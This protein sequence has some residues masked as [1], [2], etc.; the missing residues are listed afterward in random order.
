MAA[1][2][3]LLL[4][5]G[6]E[7]VARHVTSLTN[8]LAEGA[9]RLDVAV[10]TPPPRAGIVTIRPRALAVTSRRLRDAGVI[11]SVREDTIRLA[12]HCYSTAGE[13]ATVVGVLAASR[14]A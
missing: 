11:H 10:V 3:A 5:L 1:S 14:D 6:V 13:I 8:E 7:R 9:S 12:P 2:L 4:E